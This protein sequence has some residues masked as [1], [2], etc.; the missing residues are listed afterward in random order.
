MQQEEPIDLIEYNGRMVP[1]EGFRAYV[2]H[3]DGHSKI[4]NS[5]TEFE[6]YC[7]S[8]DWFAT[9]DEALSRPQDVVEDVTPESAVVTLELKPRK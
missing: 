6:L 8:N 1:K 7:A 9:Q 5:W 2:Y 3:R 4:A